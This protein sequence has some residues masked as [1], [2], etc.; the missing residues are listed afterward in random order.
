MIAVG[1]NRLNRQTDHDEEIVLQESA[2]DDHP[3]QDGARAATM[4]SGRVF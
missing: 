2:D 4:E 1:G 3:V